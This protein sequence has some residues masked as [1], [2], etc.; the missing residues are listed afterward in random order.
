MDKK[1]TCGCKGDCNCA[2]F[3]NIKGKV[4][5]VAEK[6]VEFAKDT[7]EKYDNASPATKKKIKTGIGIVAGLIALKKIFGRK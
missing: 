1:K 2:N 5:D 3:E 4:E 6:A 7:K